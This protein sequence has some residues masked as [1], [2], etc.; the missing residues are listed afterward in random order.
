MAVGIPSWS[1]HDHLDG[2]QGMQRVLSGESMLP[3]LLPTGKGLACAQLSPWHGQEHRLAMHLEQEPG[4]FS[5]SC[6]LGTVTLCLSL[7]TQS[8]DGGA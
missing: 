4:Q 5:R 1:I 7:P 3:R 8:R 2:R 6:G